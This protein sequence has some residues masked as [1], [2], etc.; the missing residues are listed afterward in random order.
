MM[1]RFGVD[2]YR[3][4][5]VIEHIQSEPGVDLSQLSPEDREKLAALLERA[6]TEQV[7]SDSKPKPTS[8][9]VH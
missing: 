4:K 7:A 5:Q 9:S 1:A 6:Q 8:G 2:G 3:E